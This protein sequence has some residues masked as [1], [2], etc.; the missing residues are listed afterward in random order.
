M[1]YRVGRLV[2]VYGVQ[3]GRGHFLD[4]FLHAQR[5]QSRE[6]EMGQWSDPM[7]SE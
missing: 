7:T 1:P 6:M 2:K 5:G 4:P 3:P